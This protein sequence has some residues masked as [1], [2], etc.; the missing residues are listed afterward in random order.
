MKEKLNL[1]DSMEILSFGDL[2]TNYP[3]HYH[4]TYCISFIQK[5]LIGENEFIASPGNILI[6]HPYELHDNR[7]IENIGVTFTSFYINQEVFNAIS[8]FK[9][10]SFNNKVIENTSLTNQ[11]GALI[12]LVR[13]SRN[14]KNFNREFYSA[15]HQF[16]SELSICYGA[17]IPYHPKKSTNLLVEVKEF[18]ASRLNSKLNLENLTKIAGM[19]SFQFIRWFKKQVGITPFEYI[20][21]KRI[22]RSKRLIREGMPLVNV[23]L[24]SGFYDQSHFSNYF[25]KYVG[26]TP[27][28]YRHNCNIFQDI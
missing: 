24:D 26:M 1:F 5:G 22:G 23:S 6:S 8:S 20:L 17:D 2:Q 15:F 16:I 7:L 28:H 11:I 4:D 14:R 21:I 12:R 19:N 25:K 3:V 13:S 9:N 18:I 10:V 27:K